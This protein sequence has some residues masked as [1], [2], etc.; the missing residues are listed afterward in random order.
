VER[1]AFAAVASFVVA[2]ARDVECVGV[3]LEHGGEQRVELL[4]AIEVR[5][6]E[7]LARHLAAAHE[8]L[9]LGN[10]GLDERVVVVMVVVMMV[11]VVVAVTVVTIMLV[12]RARALPGGRGA[13][14]D[15]EC[16]AGGESDEVATG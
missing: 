2:I 6:R 4:D 9:E 5:L 12:A 15:D 14:A 10:V 8:P 11:V 1:T 3:H 16:R 13:G 7:V